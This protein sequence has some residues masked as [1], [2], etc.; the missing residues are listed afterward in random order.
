MK[1][2]VLL[3]SACVSLQVDMTFSLDK[4]IELENQEIWMERKPPEKDVDFLKSEIDMDIWTV[5]H[6]RVSSQTNDR[7]YFVVQSKMEIVRSIKA[8]LVFFSQSSKCP[9]SKFF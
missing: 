3:S 5:R 1:Q 8:C 4:I 2:T 9:K 7:I 6:C